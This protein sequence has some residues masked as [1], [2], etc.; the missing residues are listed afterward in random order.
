MGGALVN[1][2]KGLLKITKTKVIRT[3][4]YKLRLK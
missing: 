3:A 4:K 1:I 2:T